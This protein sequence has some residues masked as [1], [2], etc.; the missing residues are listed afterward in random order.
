MYMYVYTGYI[1]ET[2][3]RQHHCSIIMQATWAGLWNTGTCVF[4]WNQFFMCHSSH[5]PQ[6]FSLYQKTLT[7]PS[8]LSCFQASRSAPNPQKALH[9]I[10]PAFF[11][12]LWEKYFLT[13]VQCFPLRTVVLDWSRGFP[14]SSRCRKALITSP[15]PWVCLGK[16]FPT[17]LYDF[18]ARTHCL[19]HFE[20]RCNVENLLAFP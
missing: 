19:C 18:F 17:F 11:D 5:F 12:E 13:L 3:T 16:L 7:I 20:T 9:C 2:Q 8:R 1:L 4:T 6:T 15:E 10:Q 14:D